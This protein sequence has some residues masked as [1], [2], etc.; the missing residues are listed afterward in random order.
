LADA[1]VVDLDLHRTPPDA[2]ELAQRRRGGLPP[3]QEAMLVDWG[4]PHVL[5][6]WRFHM[7]LTRRLT[8]DERAEIQPAAAAH[9]AAALAIP[10]RVEE[11]CLFTQIAPGSPLMLAERLPLGG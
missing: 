11:I 2:A 7:T 6:T 4:Y 10:R 1:C 8:A 3:E 5:S 9:F